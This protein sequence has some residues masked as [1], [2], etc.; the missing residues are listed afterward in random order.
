VQRFDA[1]TKYLRKE[2]HNCIYNIKF[3]AS[4]LIISIYN[5]CTDGF[6]FDE[7]SNL[8]FSL[9]LQQLRA[10]EILMPHLIPN[11]F[12][13]HYYHVQKSI[14]IFSNPKNSIDI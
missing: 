9:E 8:T 14:A 7:L 10:D 3:C 6:G 12:V 5:I 11:T 2:L 1:V 13:L 4:R